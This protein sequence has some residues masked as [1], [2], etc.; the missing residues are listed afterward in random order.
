MTKTKTE[1]DYNPIP[2]ASGSVYAEYGKTKLI[3]AMYVYIGGC[4]YFI[5]F[6]KITAMDPSNLG[7]YRHFRM[8]DGSNAISI[9]HHLHFRSDWLSPE[10]KLNYYSSSVVDSL[11]VY[12]QSIKE[13]DV[14][15][16]IEKALK[17]VILLDNYP[18]CTIEAH[19]WLLECDGNTLGCSINTV[20]LALVCAGIE[21]KDFIT[22]TQAVVIDQNKNKK[23]KD[24]N[25]SD[26]KNKLFL[27]DATLSEERYNDKECEITVSFMNEA[28][29]IT[30]LN[31]NGSLS[32]NETKETLQLC[33][34]GCAQL[35][36]LM[37]TSLFKYC[38]LKMQNT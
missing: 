35:K 11:I 7:R 3:V 10:G 15:S 18:K 17:S 31:M 4:V 5:H 21:M 28:K 26:D 16:N 23:E 6:I 1:F 29:Q 27:L 25:K 12:T 33:M 22:C 24:E 37:K 20:S 38:K 14:A 30:L 8:K 19:V 9:M 13:R 2:E 32:P 36:Q 34:K